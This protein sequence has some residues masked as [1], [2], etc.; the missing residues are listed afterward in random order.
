MS[1]LQTIGEFVT[2][3]GTLI[4]VIGAIGLIRLPDFFARTHGGSV[5]DTLGAGLAVLG[6]ILYT[7]GMD[8]ALDARLLIV[9]KLVSIVTFLLVTSPISGH[10]L[11]RSAYEAGIGRQGLPDLNDVKNV[12]NGILQPDAS[13]HHQGGQND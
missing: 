12:A 5:T 10:A 3:L 13:D 1:V 6:M 11:T 7:M 8:L 4:C 2:L 9:F